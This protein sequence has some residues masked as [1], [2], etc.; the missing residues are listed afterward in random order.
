M[1]F[2]KDLFSYP[3]GNDAISIKLNDKIPVVLK[4]YA[5]GNY[6]MSNP[7]YTDTDTA[8]SIT[9]GT[10]NRESSERIEKAFDFIVKQCKENAKE[11]F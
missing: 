2:I 6:D 10:D 5:L 4:G 7:N 1:T 3:S 9:I 11:P 8:D